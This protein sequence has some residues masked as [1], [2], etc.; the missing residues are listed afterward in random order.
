MPIPKLSNQQLAAAREAATQA[1]RLRADFKN[2]V[3]S[4][5]LSLVDALQKASTDDVLGQVRVFDLLKCLPRVGDK[6]AAGIMERLE[7]SPNRRVRGLGRL[8]YAAL[9]KEFGAR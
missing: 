9:V 4:G 2:Q 8:Q 3:K 1:R 5:D 7:V 6:R